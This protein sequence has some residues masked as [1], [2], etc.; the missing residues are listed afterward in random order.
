MDGVVARTVD[1]SNWTH[2]VLKA[3]NAIFI[4]NVSCPTAK[5]C[6]AVGRG[7]QGEIAGGGVLRSTNA[8]LTWKQESI[9]GGQAGF[10]VAI[11]CRSA[12]DCELVGN[13]QQEIFS[14][15]ISAASTTN[16]GA[17]WQIQLP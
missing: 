11:A 4:G 14:P 6:F 8:G 12:S 15:D 1:G 5:V 2:L 13:V 16:A 10:P 17:K 7:T 3:N 9:P